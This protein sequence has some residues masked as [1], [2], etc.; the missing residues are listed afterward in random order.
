MMLA[1]ARLIIVLSCLLLMGIGASNAQSLP[2][3]AIETR[4]KALSRELRCVVCQN[5]SIEDST[6]PLAMDLKALLRERLT[7]GDSD[8]AAKAFLVQRYGNF[9]LL[10]PP[11]QFNTLLLWFGPF[12]LLG[13]TLF[14]LRRFLSG[15]PP[16]AHALSTKP[17]PDPPLTSDEERRLSTALSEKGR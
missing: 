11:F 3:P 13:T 15:T 14:A 6:A 7:A 10:R 4:A 9:V 17:P 1:V 8:A 16:P 5:Q 2:D 12:L